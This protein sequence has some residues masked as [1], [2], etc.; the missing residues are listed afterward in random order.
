MYIKQINISQYMLCGLSL[1]HKKNM[2]LNYDLKGHKIIVIG[3]YF[4]FNSNNEMTTNNHSD[5]MHW[6]IL[7]VQN[8]CKI[9]EFSFNRKSLIFF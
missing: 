9:Y 1:L 4:K 8:F 2:Q 7:K 3:K 5:S 6:V